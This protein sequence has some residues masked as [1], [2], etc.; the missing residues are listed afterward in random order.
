MKAAEA[1]A[2][3]L[4][5]MGMSGL[6]EFNEFEEMEGGAGRLSA[7]GRVIGWYCNGIGSMRCE[8][9]CQNRSGTITYLETQSKC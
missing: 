1:E 8:W 3:D 7:R 5:R 4:C 2:N 6:P 9:L